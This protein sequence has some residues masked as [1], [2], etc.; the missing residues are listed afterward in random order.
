MFYWD[1]HYLGRVIMESA[2][3]VKH[4]NVPFFWICFILT[5]PVGDSSPK[6]N[7]SEQ[8]SSLETRV[9]VFF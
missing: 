6:Y 5:L 8:M 3:S 9:K 7:P 4:G 2:T 1:D